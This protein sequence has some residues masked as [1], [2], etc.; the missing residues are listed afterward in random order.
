MAELA[1][2]QRVV[3]AM[4]VQY[5]K[6]CKGE[7][8]PVELQLLHESLR[9]GGIS[10]PQ[11]KASMMYCCA[12]EDS[13]EP[14]ELFSVL[15]EMDR[16]YFLLQDFRWEFNLLDREQKGFI[17]EDQARFMF[18]AVH[19]NLF[20]RRRWE[21]FLRNRPVRGSGISFAEIEVDLCNIPN[22][23]EIAME[24]Y[25]E[26]REK[27]ERNKKHEGKKQ[28][29]EEAREARRKLEDEERRR[30]AEEQRK[31]DE[32][33]RRRKKEEEDRVED[34]RAQEQRQREE[35]ERGRREAA[36]REAEREKKEMEE[37]EKE[38]QR[39][40]EI[41]EVQQALEAQRELEAKAIA[42]QEEERAEMEKNKNVEDEAKEAA[43]K[44]KTAEE[45]AKKAAAAV[46]EAKDAASKKAAEEA[47]KAAKEK[48][49]RERHNKIRK[50]LKVAIKEKDKAKLQKSVKEFKDAKLADTDGDLAKAEAIL[51]R[52]KA[53][54][55]LVK[56]MD[57]RSLE[58]L[59]KAINFVKKNGFEAHM[60]QEMIKANKMLLS[61][62]RLKRL[63]DEILNLK[64]STVAEIR[65][66]S[67]PPDQ[68]HKVM[69]GTYLLLG[70]KEKELLVWK[71][72][73]ALIGKTGKEGLK[74]RVMECDPN[75]I[76]LAPAERTIVLLSKF[77]LEQ[78]RDVS[79]GAAV[80]FAWATATAEDV[81][82]RERQKAEGITPTELQKGHKTIKTEMKS[83]NIT[84]T[85]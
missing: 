29:E 53:R 82:E 28:Q 25:E 50:E 9:M 40:L 44:A 80:F 84:I 6:E 12:F 67:K 8:D 34:Q 16:R 19:G 48:A 65:S 47:E 81:I 70:N 45:E 21:K 7:L 10:I 66:Y 85:I 5:D 73:Q 15:Q 43:E 56:A 23:Q 4:F 3:D 27:E 35:E 58:D 31:K 26:L 74:R 13:C 37:K 32:D 11:V 18:E 72:M 54:D 24:E 59:E 63:R 52:F 62:K 75:K 20:S 42:L 78:V 64:Q 51:K 61:L 46:K 83:G 76:P 55:D 79:A 38:R 2:R 41:I 14:S 39:E 68:V 49:K 36:E 30:K 60:P 57:K 33:E 17:T 22:R 71:G 77:D 1:E 69:I